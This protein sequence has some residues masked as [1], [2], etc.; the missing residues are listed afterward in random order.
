MAN[1]NDAISKDKMLVPVKIGF[2]LDRLKN[3]LSLDF[4]NYYPLKKFDLEV[5]ETNEVLIDK[6]MLYLGL[7]DILEVAIQLRASKR[8]KVL[9]EQSEIDVNF[10]CM[11]FQKSKGHLSALDEYEM[12]QVP[13]ASLS[14]KMARGCSMIRLSGGSCFLRLNELQELIL[15]IK[16]IIKNN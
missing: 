14:E 3:N 4:K 9:I 8:P 6:K 11:Q 7:E 15:T 5:G 1:V 13:M 10:G 12:H 2:Q 16:C